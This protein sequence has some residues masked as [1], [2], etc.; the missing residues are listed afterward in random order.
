VV[1][2]FGGVGAGLGLGEREAADDVAPAT[3]ARKRSR[4][5]SVP[6]FKIGSP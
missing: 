6:Y 1:A 3:G 2:W 4:W 5:A